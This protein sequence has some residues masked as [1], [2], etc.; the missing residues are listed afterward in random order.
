VNSG[1]ISG[2][3]S[4]SARLRSQYRTASKMTADFKSF[5]HPA[6]LNFPARKTDDVVI[7]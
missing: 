5:R 4:V 7:T 2:V 3:Q 1:G 6:L